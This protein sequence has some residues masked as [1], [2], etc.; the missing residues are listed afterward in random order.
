MISLKHFHH[1]SAA[2]RLLAVALKYSDHHLIHFSCR[3]CDSNQTATSYY[4][5]NNQSAIDTAAGKVSSNLVELTCFETVFLM[6][7]FVFM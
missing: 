3:K 5:V 7:H 1:Y 6:F 2:D 4:K